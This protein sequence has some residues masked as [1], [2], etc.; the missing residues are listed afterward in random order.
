MPGGC[1]SS[2]HLWAVHKCSFELGGERQERT[3]QMLPCFWGAE[4][5]V[6]VRAVREDK[7]GSKQVDCGQNRAMRVAK[8]LLR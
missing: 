6:V 2:K 1:L 7:K 4:Y 5:R 3:V 8:G